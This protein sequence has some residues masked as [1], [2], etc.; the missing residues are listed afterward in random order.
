MTRSPVEADRA[1][2]R[3][4]PSQTDYRCVPICGA[5]YG[6]A[7]IDVRRLRADAAASFERAC[8]D[9]GYLDTSVV[10]CLIAVGCNVVANPVGYC[11]AVGRRLQDESVA[12]ADR[13]RQVFEERFRDTCPHGSKFETCAE[14]SNDR[15]RALD[16]FPALSRYFPTSR[17]GPPGGEGEAS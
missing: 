3:H 16:L 14:C 13:R 17:S 7:G 11:I 8:I 1:K 4:S 15:Q 2:P 9:L 6:S 10:R 12:E 5:C